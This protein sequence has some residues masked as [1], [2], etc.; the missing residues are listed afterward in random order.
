[1]WWPGLAALIGLTARKIRGKDDS[2]VGSMLL[3]GFAAQYL[4][5]VLVTRCTFIYH[6]FTAVP[7]IILMICYYFD[8][9]SGYEG[10]M[11]PAKFRLQLWCT[12][13]LC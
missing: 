7:F 10:G 8:R 6:Y 13:A 9:V 1:V 12:L 4:P 3:V 5:W 2:L 11:P